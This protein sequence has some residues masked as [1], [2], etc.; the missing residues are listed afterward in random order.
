MESKIGKIKN[1]KSFRFGSTLS[2]RYF[3][4]K[5][6]G[7]EETKATPTLNASLTSPRNGYVAQLS[8]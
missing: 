5:D 8:A 2:K 1:L 4:V 6:A 7:T 3:E